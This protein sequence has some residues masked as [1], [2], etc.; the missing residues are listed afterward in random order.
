D[1]MSIKAIHAKFIT[2]PGTAHARIIEGDF[3]FGA[4]CNSRS[5]AGI[6]KLPENE[7]DMN[8]GLM[9]VFLIRMPRDLIALN[10]IAINM[11]NGTLKSDQIEFF[12]ARDIIVEIDPV[13][14][15]TLDGEYEEGAD[16]CEIRTIDSAI[17]LIR[18]LDPEVPR[19][20]EGSAPWG[21]AGLYK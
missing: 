13:T 17:S 21:Y 10:D 11:L 1:I 19:E 16:V 5:V 20:Y 18:G 15:W 8:D 2:E 12:S 3:L 14:H 6:L 4:V 9:E 7:V